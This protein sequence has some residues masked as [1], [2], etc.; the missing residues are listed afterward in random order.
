[1]KTFKQFQQDVQEF[2]QNMMG[3]GLGILS[4]IG[5]V[6]NWGARALVG[7]SARGVATSPAGST[8]KPKKAKVK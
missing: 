2:D 6:A 7:A 1:M 4:G 5:K 3:A 8:P